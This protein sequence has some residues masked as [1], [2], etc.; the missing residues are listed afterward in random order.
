MKN[1]YS[2]KIRQVFEFAQKSVERLHHEAIEPEHLFIGMIREPRNTGRTYLTHFGVKEDLLLMRAEYFLA[3]RYA[4]RTSTDRISTVQ[5]SFGEGEGQPEFKITTETERLLR[6]SELEARML[7]A[8]EIGTEH[9][10]LAMLKEPMSSAAQ[11]L[12]MY[13]ISYESFR[14]CILAVD[15]NDK[16]RKEDQASLP[17]VAPREEISPRDE[18]ADEEDDEDDPDFAEVGESDPFSDVN[19]GGMQT[20]ATPNLDKFGVD[21]TAAAAQG[22]LDP[23]VGRTAEIERLAQILSRR[24]KN[25]P[26]LIGEPGVGKSAV[27][28]GLAQRIAKHHVNGALMQKRVFSLDLVSIVAGTKY[29]G[30][31]EERLKAVLRELR[32][33]KD[34]I[35]FID[36]IHTIV[37]AGNSTGGMDAANILKPALARGEI[38]CIGATTLEE[39]RK[40]IEKDGALDRRFQKVMVEPTSA[41]DTLTILHNIKDRY[42]QHHCVTY[43]DAAI[44]ACV[45]L[46]DRY[47]ADRKFPDK[48][49]DALDEAGARAHSDIDDFPPELERM[50]QEL[51]AVNQLKDAAVSQQK[52]EEAAHQRD[53]QLKLEA[54]IK[55]VSEEWREK[56][57]HSTVLTV[58]EDKV[59]EVVALMSNIPVQKVSGSEFDRLLALSSDLQAQ[60][61]GQNEAVAK[62]VKSIQRNRVGLKDPNH[63]IGT[64]LFIGPTG[65]GKTHLAQSLA[66][67][68]FVDEASFIR[69][70][71]SEYMEQHTVAKLIGAPP[72]YV[73]YEQAGQ[74]TEQV[75]RHP[76]SVVL[77][78][79]IEK[80]HTGIYNLLLQIMDEGRL[81]DSTGRTIDFRN[82]VI[83][84]TSNIGSRKLKDFG[85]GI[86]FN[87]T[88]EEGRKQLSQGIVQK[89][90]EKT[91]SP[92]FLNRVD[93]VISFN[94]LDREAIR[95]IVDLE[96]N[97]TAARIEQMGYHITIDEPTRHFLT[98]HGYDP[99]YGARPLKRAIRQY[100]EDVLC[101]TLLLLGRDK[102]HHAR[103]TLH[104][105]T[106]AAPDSVPQ[107]SVTEEVSEEIPVDETAVS[108]TLAALSAAS[109]AAAHQDTKASDSPQCET[110][111]A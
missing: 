24:K 101:E 27:V 92:E 9:I 56:S 98:A 22:L 83:I 34:V 1:L 29:R 85:T 81:T 19:S 52:F 104:V 91:F 25:N 8:T 10:L 12:K 76:Y 53:L 66:R 41:D 87:T 13:D 3:R 18:E 105:T 106:D 58:D 37:G 100:I 28:E 97:K 21:L 102:E 82:T 107:I 78:D 74:L 14:S 69:F 93:E 23:V 94:A 57:K 39:F 95:H 40:S 90:L 109:E 84:M 30:Q 86:G 89:E 80:A 61:I 68:L 31:F 72:G 35:L 44:E 47:L 73:G 55:L 60:V 59:A 71:M 26:I 110:S 4:K 33:N 15:N 6:L 99:N 96:W 11:I 79:E 49:I 43:T 5:I 111:P 7:H 103:Y 70:D 67:L 38:Q 16:I 77:L 17:S 54:K 62:V 63:P 2:E 48:A 32:N 65:V 46:T 42:E 36:E 75:R 88:G 64:F 108:P 51:R 45:R 50:E 20:Q